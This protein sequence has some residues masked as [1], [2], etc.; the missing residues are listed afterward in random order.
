ML[1]D[2]FKSKQFN[3]RKMV[4]YII[5][6]ADIDMFVILVSAIWILP[7]FSPKNWLFLQ[8]KTYS[9]DMFYSWQVFAKAP[10][11]QLD[12]FA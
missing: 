6:I 2:Q 3:D 7:V 12:Y 9:D 5:W 4:C 1:D 11:I 10:F 8:K